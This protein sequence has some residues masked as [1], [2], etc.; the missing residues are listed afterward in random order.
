MLLAWQARRSALQGE[1]VLDRAGINGG[2]QLARIHSRMASRQLFRILGEDTSGRRGTSFGHSQ[3]LA[4]R[5]YSG[6]ARSDGL[7]K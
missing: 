6:V 7:I 1:S 2:N 3:S 4:I 5:K